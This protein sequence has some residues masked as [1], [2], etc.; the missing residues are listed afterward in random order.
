[1]FRKKEES[2]VG[3]EFIGLCYENNVK[4]ESLEEVFQEAQAAGHLNLIFNAVDAEKNKP[5]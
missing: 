4:K 2:N 3:T 5:Y 1:M